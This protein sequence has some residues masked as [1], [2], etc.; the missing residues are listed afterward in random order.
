MQLGMGC[1]AKFEEDESG[2][3]RISIVNLSIGKT[4]DRLM[5]NHPK[6]GLSE[7]DKTHRTETRFI[8]QTIGIDSKMFGNDTAD[9]G[10]KP[11]IHGTSS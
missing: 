10:G 1:A 5:K 7:V 4:L 8:R 2:T 11:V 6:N 3:S 9:L